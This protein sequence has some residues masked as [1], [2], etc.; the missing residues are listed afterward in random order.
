MLTSLQT[1]NVSIFIKIH[2]REVYQTLVF[3]KLSVVIMIGPI[4]LFQSLRQYY[5][6]M[7]IYLP[8]NTNQGCSVNRKSSFFLF[9]YIQLIISSMLFFSYKAES[10][11]EFG[12]SFYAVI[13]EL[14]CTW[15]FL[16]KMFQMPKILKLIEAFE[17]FIEKSKWNEFCDWHVFL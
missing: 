5:Q 9:F 3:S 1:K 14:F 12:A 4:Q 7:G 11:L 2:I 8:K 13:S 6:T 16:I 10:V 15:Y 17:K